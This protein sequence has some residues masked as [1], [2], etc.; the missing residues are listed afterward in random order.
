MG[1]SVYSDGRGEGRANCCECQ[2]RY[3][4][5]LS[6]IESLYVQSYNCTRLSFVATATKI[7]QIK[8]LNLET[9]LH[10]MIALVYIIPLVA[11]QCNYSQIV[12]F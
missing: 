4:H 3:G 7:V 10:M 6:M 2:C 12:Q 11:Q 8:L 1:I 5:R 9:Q